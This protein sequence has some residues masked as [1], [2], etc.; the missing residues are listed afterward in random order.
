MRSSMSQSAALTSM[1]A[2]RS[3]GRRGSAPAA[4]SS[5]AGADPRG[6]RAPPRGG[7]GEGAGPGVETPAGRL[8]RHAGGRAGERVEAVV[9]LEADKGQAGVRGDPAKAGQRERAL[10][11]RGI[12]WGAA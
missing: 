11:G 5:G 10:N 8:A 9:L 2:A 3:A 4:A 6:A 12:G 7:G 1:S